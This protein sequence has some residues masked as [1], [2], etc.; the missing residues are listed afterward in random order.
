MK[1]HDEGYVLAYVMVIILVLCLVAL[2]MLGIAGSNLKSQQDSIARMQD[3][4]KAMGE[5]EK[6]AAQ[7]DAF[8]SG[9]E[10]SFHTVF[11]YDP[12]I[13][14]DEKSFIATRSITPEGSSVTVTAT[15]LVKSTEKIE[16]K[17][18]DTQY[19]YILTNPTWEYLSYDITTAGEGTP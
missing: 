13:Q 19:T 16:K 17:L 12:A 18:V 15:F 8:V 14:E 11:G 4:Y 5:M 3:K 2:S 9:Q 6:V 10:T 7:F 1:K